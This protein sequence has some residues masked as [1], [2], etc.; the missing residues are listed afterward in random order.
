MFISYS[1]YFR[2]RSEE[3]FYVIRSDMACDSPDHSKVNTGAG[4]FVVE[5]ADTQGFLVDNDTGFNAVAGF[6]HQIEYIYA[7]AE[8]YVNAG[9]APLHPERLVFRVYRPRSGMRRGVKMHRS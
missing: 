3:M 5:S 8:L 1:L 9:S 7:V 4:P 2:L 6:F